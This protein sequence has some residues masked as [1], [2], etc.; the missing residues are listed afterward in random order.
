MA[1]ERCLITFIKHIV[2]NSE[3][4]DSIAYKYYGD[5]F[6]I[7]PLIM[8]NPEV[9][10]SPFV[11]NGTELIIPILENTKQENADLPP[12]KK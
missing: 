6:K 1:L 4:W 9:P 2:K 10:I 3:R 8:A 12:W 7:T 11:P 5:C